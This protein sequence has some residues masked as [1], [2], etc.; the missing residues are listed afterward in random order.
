MDKKIRMV[1]LVG[2]YHR[3][4]DEIDEAIFTTIENS[5][6]IN[7]PMVKTFGVNLATYLG[8]EYVIPC[9]NC[10]DALQIALMRLNLQKGDEVIVP[11]FTYAA[12][13]EAAVLLGLVPVLVDVDPRTFNISP[14][15]IAGAIT[16]RTKV[17]ITVHL[18]GQS[19]DMQPI[20]ELAQKHDLLVIEDDAQSLGAEYTFSD[21]TVKKTGT[22]GNI[23]TLSFFPTKILGCYGDGG[24]VIVHDAEFAEE[25]RMT[26]VHGQNIKYHHQ[27][28]G[29]NSRLDT[30]QAA[31]LN[32][33]LKH[34][35]SFIAARQA[36]ARKYDNALKDL[37]GILLPSRLQASSHVY[38]QYTIQVLDGR[39]DA[40]QAHLKAQGIPALVYYPVPMQEQMAFK[41]Y[42]RISGDLSV[43][44][45][46]TDNV[47]S[48]PIHTEMEEDV[49]D[50]IIQEIRNFCC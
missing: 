44:K 33:K 40:L 7:G 48:L 31:I 5:S 38:H 29:C 1:D 26:T 50:Y 2:Q 4:K 49:L 35:E 13:A 20:L 24:A 46:L 23:G 25:V 18:F 14:D 36:A 30:L 21:G 6:F 16:D 42:A 45:E 3:L 12:A 47:L 32:A 11:A 8:V 43:A 17:I 37:D 15:A 9:G 39:R 28:I 19:C 27:I 34:I 41:Q 10:T 22:M